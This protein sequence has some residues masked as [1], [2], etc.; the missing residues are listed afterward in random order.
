MSNQ[1]AIPPN[2][3]MAS[4][5]CMVLQDITNTIPPQP[6]SAI[7]AMQIDLALL[8]QGIV[9]GLCV[10]NCGHNNCPNPFAPPAQPSPDL[11][12]GNSEREMSADHVMAAGLID[13]VNWAP[14]FRQAGMYLSRFK[15]GHEW[16]SL[17][18]AF[19]LFK[20]RHK[21]ATGGKALKSDGRPAVIATWI[22]NARNRDPK[23][24][25]PVL[26]F[27]ATWWAWWRSLQ[28]EWRE[29]TGVGPFK[30]DSEVVGSSWPELDIPKSGVNGMYSVIAS[31]AW[32]GGAVGDDPELR[33]EWALAIADVTWVVTLLS[34]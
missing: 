18:L 3:T 15:L 8:A 2:G 30:G 12:D 19:T 24:L 11:P 32:W 27:A 13:L 16:D 26:A 33:A 9:P 25:G 21:F 7:N 10:P 34:C 23:K 14:W 4:G 31:L 5:Q 22:Q 17:L 6:L 20:G 29:L 1:K 28:P